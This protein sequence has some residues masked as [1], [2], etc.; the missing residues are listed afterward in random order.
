M[1]LKMWDYHPNLLSKGLLQSL[2]VRRSVQITIGAV[3]LA[4]VRGVDGLSHNTV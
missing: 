3:L 1:H 2:T 4:N